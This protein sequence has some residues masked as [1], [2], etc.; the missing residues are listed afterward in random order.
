MFPTMGG[1]YT[2]HTILRNTAARVHRGVGAATPREAL[3]LYRI[4]D[5]SMTSS[6]W[7]LPMTCSANTYEGEIALLYVHIKCY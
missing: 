6:R 5:S 3:I 1:T 4:L 7:H 2:D